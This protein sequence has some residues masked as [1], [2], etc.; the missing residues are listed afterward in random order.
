MNRPSFARG[1]AAMVDRSLSEPD[2]PPICEPRFER[3]W[4]PPQEGRFVE[5]E[6]CRLH[7]LESGRGRPLILLH[8]LGGLAQEIAL[9][10][11]PAAAQGWRV[12]AFDRPGYGF[13]SPPPEGGTPQDQAHLLAAAVARLGLRRPVVAGHSYGA[14]VAL[15]YALDHDAAG[16]LLLAPLIHPTRP[17]AMPLLRLATAP[18]LR[19]PMQRLVM[20]WLFRRFLA[21]PWLRRAFAPDPVP[22]CFD[23]FPFGHAIRPASIQSMARDLRGFNACMAGRLPDLRGLDVPTMIVTGDADPAVSIAE[24]SLKLHR[25]LPRSELRVLPGIGHMVQHVRPDAVQAALADLGAR[26]AASSAWMKF[27][28]TRTA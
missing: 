14:S 11:R 2:A 6:G 24:Q 15:N 5:A 20:P 1:A 10:F 22:D 25:E 9:A 23:S 7:Y 12:L 18:M 8:G 26:A 16:L 3:Y 19:W 17:L 27:H 28:R 13:S 4:G 21:A